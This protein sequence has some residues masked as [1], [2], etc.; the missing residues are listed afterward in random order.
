M[1]NPIN[2]IR[3]PQQNQRGF[4]PL[5]RLLPNVVTLSSLCITLT[6]INS[7][8][9][10]NYMMATCLILL[11]GFMDGIDGR[12]ARFLN[13]SSDFGAQLDSLV[14]FVNFGIAPG[15]VVY[16][17]INSYG[18]IKGLDWAMVLFFAICSAIRLARFN[19]GLSASNVNPVI[20]KFFFKG[21]P[22]PVGAAMS[23]LPMVLFYEFG[24]DFYT[25]QKLV[26]FYVIFVAMMMAS[27]LPTISIKKIPIK[28]D[29]IYLTLLILGSIVIGLVVRPWLTL[30]MICLIYCISL[31]ITF[32]IYLKI[33]KSS[34]NKKVSF[35]N[36]KNENL[37][38]KSF[39]NKEGLKK[40][41]GADKQKTAEI[42][43]PR[44]ISSATQVKN[45]VQE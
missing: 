12:L 22:A 27:R 39:K 37:L 26:I 30:A 41:S 23:M 2:K 34:D 33:I 1:Q 8:I 16:F 32:F 29:N 9:A 40:I 18:N 20:E 19:V 36:K 17:W 35:K 24:D 28:N 6:A 38:K 44:K 14:D 5:F 10:G 21:V 3:Y 15:F 25:N 31:P 13:S 42:F 11:A 43:R 4:F 45:K 7:S